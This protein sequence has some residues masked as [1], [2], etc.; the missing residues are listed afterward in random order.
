MANYG[1]G[2][3]LVPLRS[4]NALATSRFSWISE[5][6]VAMLEIV[7][8]SPSLCIFV[9]SQTHTDAAELRRA[10]RVWNKTRYAQKRPMSLLMWAAAFRSQL[11][12]RPVVLSRQGRIQLLGGAI[13]TLVVGCRSVPALLRSSSASAGWE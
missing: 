4:L 13:S 3:T 8:E 5:L 12:A 11:T 6:V 2:N 1:G 10:S 7:S 9:F